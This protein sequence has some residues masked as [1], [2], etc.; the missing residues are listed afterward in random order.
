[1]QKIYQKLK[2]KQCDNIII[3]LTSDKNTIFYDL[4]PK[5]CQKNMSLGIFIKE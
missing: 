1:M 2:Q 5:K 3:S 4:Q